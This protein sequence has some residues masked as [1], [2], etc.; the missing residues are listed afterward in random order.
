MQRERLHGVWAAKPPPTPW[1][2][3]FTI[4]AGLVRELVTRYA[5]HG[6]HGVYTTGTDGEMHVLDRSEF[7]DLAAA[8]GR[9][10]ADSGLPAQMGCTW[11]HTEGVI[12]RARVAR[13]NGISTI[14]I[15][16][17]SWVPLSD[18][19]ILRFFAALQEAVPDMH[20]VH[21]NISRAGRV[22]TGADYRAILDVAPN[23]IGSNHTGGDISSLIEV[24]QRTPDLDLF[25]VHGQIVPGALFGARGFYSFVA[26]LAPQIAIRLWNHCHWGQW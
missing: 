6:L 16:L 4:D 11:S 5:D 13:D 24:P 7:R 10:A 12:E 23:L 25:V 20:V 19:E 26:N 22:L 15:A 9:S 2:A 14:Q 3:G 18:N 17:P 8:F 21:Y 1:D